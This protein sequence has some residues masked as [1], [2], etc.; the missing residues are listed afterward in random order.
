[1]TERP[2][3]TL[4]EIRITSARW[5]EVWGIGLYVGQPFI[6]TE[7]Q[8]RLSDPH[9]PPRKVCMF[10]YEDGRVTCTM[11]DRTREAY[12]NMEA[13]SEA[14]CRTGDRI[15]I[16]ETTLIEILEAPVPREA[17]AE[18]GSFE[19][20]LERIFHSLEDALTIPTPIEDTPNPASVGGPQ[21]SVFIDHR[22]LE[23]TEPT[24][25]MPAPPAASGPAALRTRSFADL[26]PVPLAAH[27]PDHFLRPKGPPVHSRQSRPQARPQSPPRRKNRISILLLIL[28]GI[29]LA[30]FVSER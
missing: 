20:G 23:V 16:G 10:A 18:P 15:F 25:V 2:P 1:M 6:I 7:D 26:Q 17:A 4:I 13:R 30:L 11:I 27:R 22:N 5:S 24:I 28:L 12:F 14:V 19:N 3:K 21:R 29:T 9:T 8:I